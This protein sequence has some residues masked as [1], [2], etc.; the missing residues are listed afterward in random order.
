MVK[1]TGSVLQVYLLGLVEFEAA[2]ALQRRLVFDVAGE[3]ESAALILCE[4]PPLISVGR[5]GSWAH[6]FADDHELRARQWRVRWVN[7][8]GGCVLHLP[9]QLAIYPI[10]PLR[11]HQLGIREYLDRLQAVLIAVLKDFSVPAHGRPDQTGIWVGKRPIASI[12]VAVRDWVSYY[13]A[14]LNI[15]PPLHLFRWLQCGAPGDDS[16]TSIAKER[17]GALKPS[18]VRERFLEHFTNTFSFERMSLF[19]DHPQLRRKAATDV[20]ATRR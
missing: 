3:P 1:S 8:G 11:Y 4:H 12:G 15:S 5:Q 16:M 7:R 6:I 13:G 10:L 9:G 14:V 18:L 20:V 17:R 2:L 19:S